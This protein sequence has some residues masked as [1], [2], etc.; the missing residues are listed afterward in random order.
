MAKSFI[1]FPGT[2]EYVPCN[3]L[4]R[5]ERVEG[6]RFV[7]EALLGF[8]RPE[9]GPEDRILVFLTDEARKANWEGERYSDA[10]GLRERLNKMGLPAQITDHS[11]PAGKTEDEIWKIFSC[12]YDALHENEEI[13]LDITHAFRFIPMLTIIAM[14]F[15]GFMKNVSIR[16]IYYGAVEAIGS[17]RQL[18]EMRLKERNAPVFDLTSFSTLQQWSSAADVFVNHGDSRKLVET[19]QHVTSKNFNHTTIVDP[20]IRATS[21]LKKPLLTVTECIETN[22]GPMIVNGEIFSVL[23][24]RI[25]AMQAESANKTSPLMLLLKRI[26]KKIQPF[27]NQ[28]LENGIVAAEWCLEHGLIQQGITLFQET[29]ISLVLE[30]V[31]Q[32]WSDQSLRE[33]VTNIFALKRSKNGLEKISR[34]NENKAIIDQILM[35]NDVAT[36]SRCFDLVTKTRNDINHGGFKK[37]SAS[38]PKHFHNQLQKALETLRNRN[39]E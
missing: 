37:N 36:F 27:K 17:I 29:L 1:T 20:G 26:E 15:A 34:M 22:R 3:Y 9:F 31:E 32:D 25:K 23:R 30:K 38:N 16:G 10:T 24:E 7:Q 35:L 11:I 4:L 18:K 33:L 21:G 28:E 5:G 6:V 8:L 39:A 19:I 2:N 13:I 12:V 14:N